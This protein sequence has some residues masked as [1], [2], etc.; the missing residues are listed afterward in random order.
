M[1]YDTGALIAGERR[2]DTFWRAHRRTLAAGI[3]PLVPAAVLAEAWR[4][5]PAPLLSNLLRGTDIIS[6]DASAARRAG[7]LQGL[8][9]GSISAVDATVVELAMRTNGA[10]MTSDPVDIGRLVSVSGMAIPIV[11]I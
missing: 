7:V 3:L 5:G 9:G 11:S 6:L 1:I 4:G 10:I 8:A 2:K